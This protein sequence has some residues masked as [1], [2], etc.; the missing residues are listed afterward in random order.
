MIDALKMYKSQNEDKDFLFMHCFKK[1]EGCKKWDDIRLTLNKD[2]IG[3]DGP[4]DPV[5]ASTGL[6]LETRRPRPRGMQRRHWPPWTPPSR[7]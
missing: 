2:G 5:G 4:V 1:L 3:E 6:P 7:R